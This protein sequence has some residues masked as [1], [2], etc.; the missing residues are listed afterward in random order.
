M[1]VIVEDEHGSARKVQGPLRHPFLNVMRVSSWGLAVEREGGVSE[2]L[3]RACNWFGQGHAGRGTGSR[4][5]VEGRLEGKD[6][7]GA[8]TG[9][10]LA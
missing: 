4:A 7:T 3:C 8:L 2:T 10:A 1:C 5:E 6:D 9:L